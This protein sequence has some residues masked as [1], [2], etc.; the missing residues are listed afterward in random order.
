MNNY[1]KGLIIRILLLLFIV[2]FSR[3][4]FYPVLE[5]LTARLSYIFLLPL[6][7]KIIDSVSFIIKNQTIEIIPACIAFSAYVLL[8]ALTLT[9]KGISLKTAA[10]IFLF[11]SLSIL[12]INIIRIDLLIYM[13]V[14]VGSKLYETVHLLFWKIL[15]SIIVVAVWIIFTRKYNI[16][17]IPVYSDIKYLIK[18]IKQRG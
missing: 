11:G 6:N 4:L 8:A 14:L 10:K 5:F 2:F 9:T 7:P 16:K 18:K 3:D 1:I 15:S 13:L 12:T 17:E